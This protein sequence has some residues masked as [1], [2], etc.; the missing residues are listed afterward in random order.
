MSLPLFSS[1]FVFRNSDIFE[2]GGF[3]SAP[4]QADYGM[5]TIYDIPKPV[6]RAFEL[7]HWSGDTRLGVTPTGSIG[8]ADVLSTRNSTHLQIYVSNFNTW[9]KPIQTETVCV[10][11]TGL[12]FINRSAPTATL[13]RIDE[14]SANAI[15][16]WEAMGSPAYPTPAQI[17]AM[18]KA[19]LMKTSTINYEFRFAI[20]RAARTLRKIPNEPFLTVFAFQCWQGL[21]PRRRAATWRRSYCCSFE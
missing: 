1:R 17:D 9:G 16:T 7:L 2:E 19:S 4:F 14:N 12:T 3:D 10:T 20:T 15:K 5:T 21:V 8:N 11:L 13:T 18:Y 6:Y